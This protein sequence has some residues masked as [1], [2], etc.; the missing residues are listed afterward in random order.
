MNPQSRTDSRQQCF[1]INHNN[2]PYYMIR[3]DLV[4][5]CED[6]ELPGRVLS[7]LEFLSDNKN[8]ERGVRAVTHTIA[9]LCFEMAH[10]Y[11]PAAIRAALVYLRKQGFLEITERCAE[12][13]GSI[14]VLNV[15]AINAE[16][17]RICPPQRNRWDALRMVSKKNT[18]NP[19]HWQEPEGND[20]LLKISGGTPPLLK[21]SGP[22]AKNE[23]ASI[24]QKLSSKKQEHRDI[25]DSSGVGRESETADVHASQIKTQNVP[26][27]PIEPQHVPSE[28]IQVPVP[29]PPPPPAPPPPAAKPPADNSRLTTFLRFR[30]VAEKHSIRG[31]EKQWDAAFEDYW[32]K[33]TM[34][35]NLAATRGVLYLDK[36]ENTPTKYLTNPVKYLSHKLW[37]KYDGLAVPQEKPKRAPQMESGEAIMKRDLEISRKG[38]EAEQERL[39]A[40][41]LHATTA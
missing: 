28:P 35:D 39:K 27:E 38:W 32:S 34:E 19:N 2:Y 24:Y 18:P 10:Q 7:L 3:T 41:G 26:N 8:A 23:R 36:T 13:K 25:Q 17:D 1:H 22:P 33:Q 5:I 4:M 15:D 11:S 6:K 31:S 37:Q 14:Y 29:P 21:I 20:P 12:S 9:E 16:I 40:E 30:T